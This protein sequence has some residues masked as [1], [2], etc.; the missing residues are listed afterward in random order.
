MTLMHFDPVRDLERLTEQALAQ[1]RGPRALPMEALRRGDGFLI[2]M[3]MPGVEP[4]GVDVS[5]ERNVVTVRAHRQP[6]HEQG[7]ELIVDERPTGDFSRQLY[8][9]ENLDA[10]QLSA[11]FHG[12]VLLLR[13]P[14]AEAIQSRKVEIS[15][16]RGESHTVEAG[17]AEP[18]NA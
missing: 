16:R 5:V 6:L 14:V 3:D 10:T 13:I 15:G 11:D 7:D 1:S 12:G 17:S 9:G 4:A 18:A 8:P 2:A